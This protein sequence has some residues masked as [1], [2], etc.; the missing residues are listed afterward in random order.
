MYIHLYKKGLDPVVHATTP[1][2]CMLSFSQ[3][4]ALLP[5]ALSVRKC[6]LFQQSVTFQDVAIDFSQEE[7]GFL[8]PAQRK[9]YTAVM[10]EN[11]QNLV[12]LGK[13]IEH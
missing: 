9:L 6:L 8:I 3:D 11:Y 1:I 7:W 5:E 10:S 12:W 4:F 13:G 2:P